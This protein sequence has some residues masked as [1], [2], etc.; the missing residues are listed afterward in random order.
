M[1]QRLLPFLNKLVPTA[2]AVK[3]LGKIDPRL[4][5]FFGAAAASGYTA[6]SAL[7]FVRNKIEGRTGANMAEEQRLDQGMARGTLRPDEAAS[8]QLMAES[9][10]IPNALQNA[11]RLAYVM[12]LA[13]FC[14]SFM[15]D[16]GS[17]GIVNLLTS[18]CPSL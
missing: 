8:R 18:E 12:A 9:N 17:M 5:K 15:Y 13:I 14:D 1:I 10:R 16:F 2:L 3:G 7:D 6:D 11:Y 4:E